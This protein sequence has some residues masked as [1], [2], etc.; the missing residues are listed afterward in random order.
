[1]FA[2]GICLGIESL[3]LNPQKDHYVSVLFT[4][5]KIMGTVLDK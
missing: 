4:S 2:L 3:R 5:E 1:M